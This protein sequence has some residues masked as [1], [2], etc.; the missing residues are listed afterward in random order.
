MIAIVKNQPSESVTLG[1][2]AEYIVKLP[3]PHQNQQRHPV[4]QVFNLKIFNRF[5]E[6]W[7]VPRP[8]L[9]QSICLKQ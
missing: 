9:I 7:E 6:I 3:A 4:V 2:N 8:Q 5:F 1:C